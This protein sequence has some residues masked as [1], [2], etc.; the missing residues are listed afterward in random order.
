[1]RK[2]FARASK[3]FVIDVVDPT[4]SR[5]TE[6]DRSA[7]LLRFRFFGS[8]RWSDHFRSATRPLDFVQG[9]LGKDVSP[10]GNLPGELAGAENFQPGI[11]LL[12]DSARLERFRR[13]SV[14]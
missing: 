4:G 1:M 5:G 11:E 2:T 6:P 13:K 9:G 12:N 7:S 14:A 10:H 3:N 8:R